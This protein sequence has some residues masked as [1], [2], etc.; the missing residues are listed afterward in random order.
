[1]TDAPLLMLAEGRKPRPCKAPQMRP[2]EIVL[3]MRLAGFL[4]AYMRPDWQWTHISSGE[5]RDARIAAKLK[6]MGLA[7]GWPDI[8]LL[9]SSGVAH[10]IELKRSEAGRLSEA[11]Q[12]FCRWC[13]AHGVAHVVASTFNAALDALR[14]WGALTDEA[15]AIVGGSKRPGEVGGRS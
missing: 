3:H 6:A 12:S 7:C 9:S 15:L 13:S 1:M 8:L 11:Q 5:R 14:R 4:R 10:F 2:K